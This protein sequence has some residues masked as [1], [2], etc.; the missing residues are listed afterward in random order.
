MEDIPVLCVVDIVMV[1]RPPC[2]ILSLSIGKRIIV[3]Y[4]LLIRCREGEL[5]MCKKVGDAKEEVLLDTRASKQNSNAESSSEPELVSPK[6][7]KSQDS[8]VSE[9]LEVSEIPEIPEVTFSEEHKR[10]NIKFSDQIEF[11]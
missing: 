5:R 4:S 11:K 6:I 9:G 2:A 8:E 7:E 3:L 1:I 10:G